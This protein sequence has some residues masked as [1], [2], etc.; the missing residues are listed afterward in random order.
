MNEHHT[1][2]KGTFGKSGGARV[3]GFMKF[4]SRYYFMYLRQLHN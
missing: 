2:Q 3:D 1:K 4:V